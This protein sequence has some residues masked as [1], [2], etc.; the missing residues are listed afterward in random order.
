MSIAHCSA[1]AVPNRSTATALQTKE[2]SV[3]VTH[4]SLEATM[5][6]LDARSR[7]LVVAS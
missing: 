5:S 1:P 3:I 2:N 7:K 6:A 4:R